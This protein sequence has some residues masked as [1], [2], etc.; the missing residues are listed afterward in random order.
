MVD[1]AENIMTDMA[2]AASTIFAILKITIFLSGAEATG[3]T[4]GTKEELAG[5]GSPLEPGISI[6]NLFIPI[7][8]P[9][10]LRS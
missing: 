8:T 9:I 10:Y 1:A 3:T 5:G 4:V 2:G 7:P 6:P